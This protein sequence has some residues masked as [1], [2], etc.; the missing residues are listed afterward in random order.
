MK[1]N[2]KLE[3]ASFPPP[4]AYTVGSPLLVSISRT[5]TYQPEPSGKAALLAEGPRMP[6]CSSLPTVKSIP[7]L[8]ELTPG[9]LKIA[10]PPKVPPPVVSTQVS[11]PLGELY[12]LWLLGSRPLLSRL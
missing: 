6:L 1:R 3:P 10:R 8:S 11:K 2:E 5:A 7:S 4:V 9:K 12:M